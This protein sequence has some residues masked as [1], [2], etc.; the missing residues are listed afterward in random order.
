[1]SLGM[2]QVPTK[3]SFSLPKASRRQASDLDS[4][5]QKWTPWTLTLREKER[6]EG[7]GKSGKW[8][9]GQQWQWGQCWQQWRWQQWPSHGSVW[10]YGAAWSSLFQRRFYG[11][12]SGHFDI[13]VVYKPGSPNSHE[14]VNYPNL[15]KNSVSVL[16]LFLFFNQ[17]PYLF[18]ITQNSD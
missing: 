12:V 13:G 5:K 15:P 9:R 2:R 14:S 4:A 6:C 1:M 10:D 7:A 18:L 11:L 17:S 3:H 8:L 16:G